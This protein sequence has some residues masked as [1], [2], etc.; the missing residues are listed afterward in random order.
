MPDLLVIALAGLGTYVLRA[1]FLLRRAE[2]AGPEGPGP[3]L[4]LVAPAVLAAIALPAVLAPRGEVSLTETVPSLVA[5]GVALLVWRR[6]RGFPLAMV[7]GLVAW[8][9]ALAVVQSA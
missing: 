6:T 4:E 3:A 5:A 7:C 1:V 2:A 8:W 9:L